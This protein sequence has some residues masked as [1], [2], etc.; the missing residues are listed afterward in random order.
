MDDF[1]KQQKIKNYYEESNYYE[2]NLIGFADLGSRF[3]KYRINKLLEIY[4]P[5]K[6]EKVVDI[7]C[8]W[9]TFCF[10]L[11][12][13]CHEVTGIDYSKKSIEMCLEHRDKRGLNNIEFI[14]ADAQKI[15]LSNET[16]DVIVCADIF[17]H[18][19]PDVFE[20]V[21]NE[22]ARLLKKGGKLIAWTPHRGHFIEILRNNNIILRKDVGH[23]DYKSMDN[24]K[25]TIE[26]NNFSI[27]KAYYAG[28]HNPVLNILEWILQ[29]FLPFMRRRIAILAEKR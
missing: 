8:G 5:G 23:V 11:A 14:C 3:Q 1:E 18:L 24:L 4:R 17:E 28:S 10:A 15:P 9:G 22:C 25:E 27:L 21:L 19:Y 13:L 20:K 12:P 29:P 26:K 6:D 7:G 16:Y 2:D